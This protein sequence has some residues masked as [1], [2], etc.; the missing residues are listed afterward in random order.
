MKGRAVKLCLTAVALG[1]AV[2]FALA[3][4]SVGSP[5]SAPVTTFPAAGTLEISGVRVRAEPDPEATVLRLIHYFRS[6]YRVQEIL[7]VGSRVG[8]NG[9]LWY[10]ISVPGRPN[11]RLGWIPA[12]SVSLKPTV[13]KVVVHRHTRR[14]DL[15]WYGKHVWRGK[16]AVGAP[17]METPIGLFYATARFVPHDD[18]YLTTYAVETSGYSKLT[19]WPGGGVFGIHGTPDPS[20]LGKA[21]SHGC[22]R[23]S[24]QTA[25]KLRRYVP[26]GTP[27]FITRT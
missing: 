11:G 20:S 10:R 2:A 3:T 25:L 5:A 15:Y 27:I 16:V 1:V 8:S 21:A 7:A 13:A 17:G 12:W 14:I 22:V 9:Q 4:P 24:A 6:D 23:V 19:E 26:L 18:P